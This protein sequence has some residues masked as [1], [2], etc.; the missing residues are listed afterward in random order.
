MQ[1]PSFPMGTKRV[2]AWLAL[3]S[4]ERERSRLRLPSSSSYNQ[5]PSLCTTLYKGK[6]PLTL[7]HSRELKVAI[8]RGWKEKGRRDAAA[9]K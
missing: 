4:A 3:S 7:C 2:S 1:F 5:P 9:M 8:Q 6:A